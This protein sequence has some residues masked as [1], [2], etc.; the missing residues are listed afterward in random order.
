MSYS[1]LRLDVQLCFP[2]YAASKEV[3]RLYDPL[4]KPLGLTYTQYVF[5]LCLWEKD[6]QTLKELGNRLHLDSGTLSPLLEK[7]VKKGLVEKRAGE[8]DRRFQLIYL[9]KEG[10][11]LEEKAK[12]IP[13]RIG[14]CLNLEEEEAKTLYIL[15]YKLLSSKK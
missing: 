6:G 12:E 1:C 4:L 2:L 7:L 5:L 13:G 3:V 8:E 11:K 9:T 15:L 14:S 10:K